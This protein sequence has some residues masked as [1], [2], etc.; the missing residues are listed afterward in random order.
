MHRLYLSLLIILFGGL[1]YAAGG[2]TD[3][4]SYQGRLTDSGTFADGDYEF[5]FDLWTIA[6]TSA[7]VDTVTQTLT[8][9]NGLFNT[10]L[11]FADNFRE[12]PANVPLGHELEIG[13]RP[14]GSPDPFTVLSRQEV[15]NAPRAAF[16]EQGT[17][18]FNVGDEDG[19]RITLTDNAGLARTVIEPDVNGV[20]QYVQLDGENGSLILN[21]TNPGFGPTLSLSGTGGNVFLSPGDPVANNRVVLPVSSISGAEIGDE[22]GVASQS[23]SPFSEFLPSTDTALAAQTIDC[24]AD[25]YIIAMANVGMGAF[26]STAEVQNYFSLSLDGTTPYLGE[27]AIQIIQHDNTASIDYHTLSTTKV[28][29]VTSGMTTVT[30]LGRTTVV[31]SGFYGRPI[32]LTLLYVP[33]AYGATLTRGAPAG[34]G[35][36]LPVAGAEVVPATPD[37]VPYEQM[38]EAQ[39]ALEAQMAEMRAELAR[40]RAEQ[41]AA[42]GR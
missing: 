18:S 27:E 20:G 15:L 36:S 10:E 4:I 25:G 12:T 34:P 8:V 35:A 21:M 1:A 41:K 31:G 3:F 2:P 30:L 37:P 39:R 7:L 28:I 9:E 42:R 33:T 24:P 29:P 32:D 38:M 13:V 23:T 14:A 11:P 16:A 6:N 26:S 17:N 19:G 22:P 5:K 40:V